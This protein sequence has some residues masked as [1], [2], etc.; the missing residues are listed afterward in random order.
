MHYSYFKVDSVN[1]VQFILIV[2]V[3]SHAERYN[4]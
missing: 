3:F 2:G 4:L 1:D